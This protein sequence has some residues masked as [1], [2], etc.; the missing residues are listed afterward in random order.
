MRRAL[1]HHSC[2]NNPAH[3]VPQSQLHSVVQPN[4]PIRL[5]LVALVLCS[6]RTPH[7]DEVKRKV[8]V[9]LHIHKELAV[10]G[11]DLLVLVEGYSVLNKLLSLAPSHE[12]RRP[13]P[14]NEEELRPRVVSLCDLHLDAA[15]ARTG[16]GRRRRRRL[17]GAV[18]HVLVLRRRDSG[19]AVFGAVPGRRLGLGQPDRLAVQFHHLVALRLA[20]LPVGRDVGGQPAVRSLLVSREGPV[21]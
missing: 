16:P 17:G 20:L 19:V 15:V 1:V 18:G 8:A 12:A 10:R 4:L 3:R 11:A 9:L 21:D 6:V 7:V 13:R 14:G 2:E 5:E